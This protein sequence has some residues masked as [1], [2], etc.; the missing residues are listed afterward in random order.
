MVELVN[1]FNQ[2]INRYIEGQSISAK[3]KPCGSP[4]IQDA[5]PLAIQ[6]RQDGISHPTNWV[7]ENHL[8]K[9]E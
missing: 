9:L 8:A 5:V 2:H 7:V 6:P 4:I 1:K 3:K